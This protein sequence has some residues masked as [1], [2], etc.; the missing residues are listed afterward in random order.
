MVE[1]IL[2]FIIKQE[3]N[4]LALSVNSSKLDVMTE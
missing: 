2:M 4:C 3:Y 1:A